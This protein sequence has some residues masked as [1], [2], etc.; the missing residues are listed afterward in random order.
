MVSGPAGPCGQRVPDLVAMGGLFEIAH[1]AIHRHRM[2]ALIV[3]SVVLGH[4][5]INRATFRTAHVWLTPHF[6]Y[7]L[8]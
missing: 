5:R 2:V 6:I 4:S 1:V 8:L 3:M 7:L